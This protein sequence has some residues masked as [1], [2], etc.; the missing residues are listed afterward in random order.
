VTGTY[1]IEALANHDRRNFTCGVAALDR[2]FREQVS[3][4][5]R[6]RVTNCFVAIDTAGAVAGYYT[7]AAASL[8]TTELT[9]DE[10]KRLPRY[11]LLPAALIGR[12]A[13]A[14]PDRGQGLGAALIVDA[15]VRTMRAEPAIFALIVD[16]K[17][18]AAVA[19]YTH[20]GFRAFTSRPMSLFLPV[21][22]AQRRLRTAAG[23]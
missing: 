22:E 20:L 18:E 19:F 4:D 21:A 7:F 11:P 23:D 14:A 1:I 8:P 10:V 2:Y 16:A 13:V 5:I 3:Q 6:R 9:G 17:D 12:L 15:V